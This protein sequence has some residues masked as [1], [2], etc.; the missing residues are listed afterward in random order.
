MGF[1]KL[2]AKTEENLVPTLK[3]I[4]KLKEKILREG[5]ETFNSFV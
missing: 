1:L 5:P 2:I 3:V 4:T